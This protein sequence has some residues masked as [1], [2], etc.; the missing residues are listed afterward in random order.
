MISEDNSVH[1]TMGNVERRGVWTVPTDLDV[2]VRFGKRT[3]VRFCGS[4]CRIRTCVS[5]VRAQCPA[6]R[7]SRNLIR[8]EWVRRDLNSRLIG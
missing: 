2:R 6:T 5:E 3:S 7:R 1:V 8:Y 4:G